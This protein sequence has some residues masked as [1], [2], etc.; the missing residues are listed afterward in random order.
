ME[1]FDVV[2]VGAGPAG[3]SAALFAASGGAR[4]LLVDLRQEIGHP[5][6]C[7][8]FL[9]CL[10]E[11]ESIFPIHEG[12]SEV[13]SIP[14]ETIIQRT[15]TLDCISPSMKHYPFHMEGFSVSRRSFDKILAYRAEV[16]GAELRHPATVIKVDGN[17][18]DFAS[19]DSVEAKVIVAADGPLSVV[20]RSLGVKIPRKMY[21]MITTEV[22]GTFGPTVEVFFGSLAPGGYAWVIPKGDGA[23]VGLGVSSLPK[24]ETLS[25]LLAKFAAQRD[26]KLGLDY[27]RWWV[28]IGEPPTT[29]VHGNVLLTGDAANMVM[30]TNGGG[31]PTAMITGM[32]AGKV[33]AK[34][35]FE[36]APL[37]E[38]DE[39]WK[40]N[41]LQPLRSGHSMKR[42]GDRFIRSDLLLSLGM[43]YMGRKGMDSFIRMRVPAR[44]GGRRAS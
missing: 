11:L 5:V 40:R 7:G 9:P 27:T 21:K 1:R 15:N 10:E 31:I 19:G 8:E 14:E 26:L 12:F 30:A 24:G 35:I 28:P 32:Y 36:R 16:A 43:R 20:A 38:Y 3:S 18:V 44:L 4:T 39:T 29:A 2:V 42:L 13:F 33:A 17:R 23:N 22:P 6:Q 37:S 25:T 41:L 34:H